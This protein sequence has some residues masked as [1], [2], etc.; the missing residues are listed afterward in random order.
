MSSSDERRYRRSGEA[1]SARV[2][3]ETVILDLDRD[4][5]TRLNG[6]AGMLWETLAEPRSAEQLA[7][8]LVAEY[9]IEPARAEA[10]ANTLIEKLRGRGLLAESA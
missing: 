7:A 8:A 5:Y 1:I 10:D 9:G 4:R 2:L 3:E 6:S